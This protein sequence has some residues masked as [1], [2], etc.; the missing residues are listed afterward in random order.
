MVVGA[1]LLTVILAIPMI[2]GDVRP[3][4][5]ES[6][7]F[8]LFKGQLELLALFLTIGFTEEFATRGYALRAMIDGIGFWGVAFTTSAFFGLGHYLE[9]DPLAGAAGTFEGA[10]FECMAIK[11]T[12]S[13]AFSIGFHTAWDFF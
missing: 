2:L 1:T 9:G 8:E 11:Y 10:I 4:V 12:G 13:L 6:G 3:A 5:A 7:R